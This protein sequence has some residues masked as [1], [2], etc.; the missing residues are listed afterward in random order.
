M[1]S[2]PTTIKRFDP[3]WSIN[4]PTGTCSTAYTSSWTIENAARVAAV[5]PKRALASVVATPSDE[6]CS[7]AMTAANWPT[8][9]T[10]HANR[11]RGAQAGQRSRSRRDP[12]GHALCRCDSGGRANRIEQCGRWRNHVLGDNR[13]SVV[14]VSQHDDVHVEVPGA[15]DDDVSDVVLGGLDNLAVHLDPRAGQLVNGVLD[16]FRSRTS[17]SSAVGTPL[18]QTTA[19]FTASQRDPGSMARRTSANDTPS[20]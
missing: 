5:I 2:D 4:T 11:P 17:M 7:I 12:A 16:D 9:S 13:S 3:Y 6:R 18:Y 19:R 10:V 8:V 15:P 14:L 20:R 1:I